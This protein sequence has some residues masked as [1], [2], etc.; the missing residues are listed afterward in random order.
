MTAISS[1]ACFIL[2]GAIESTKNNSVINW[3]DPEWAVAVDADPEFSKYMNNVCI[4]HNDNK[5]CHGYFALLHN[6]VS[7]LPDSANI[8]ELGNREG[9]STLA[10]LDAMKASQTF[11]TVDTVEDLRF[12]PPEK[13][14]KLIDDNQLFAIVGNCLDPEMILTVAKITN[15]KI[16]LLFCDT[17]HIYEQIKAEFEKYEHLLA[18][19]AIILVDDIQDA[20]L[21]LKEGHPDRRTKY[22]FFE[23]WE[24]EKYDI[25]ELCHYPT[26]FAAFI[27]RRKVGV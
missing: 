7:N 2:K 11:V 1:T 21:H 19:E 4:P 6:I 18:D 16:D 3:N 24:G 25:T 23:E 9:L 14:N 26:G 5:R 17:I 20:H 27:Y 12:L 22:R 10:I 8:C 13:A 15:G